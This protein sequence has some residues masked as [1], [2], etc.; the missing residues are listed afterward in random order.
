MR[1]SLTTTKS[2]S[3]YSFSTILGK[4]WNDGLKKTDLFLINF[5]EFSIYSFR[6]N[7]NFSKTSSFFPYQL[8]IMITEKSFTNTTYQT[9]KFI[10]ILSSISNY[11]V[12]PP[13]HDLLQAL[14]YTSRMLIV[15]FLMLQEEY[16][17]LNK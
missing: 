3:S 1:Q 4:H 13:V 10:I 16:Q 7:G 17:D 2:H 8:I 6:I 14:L 9:R 15:E 5:K 12:K 11:Q